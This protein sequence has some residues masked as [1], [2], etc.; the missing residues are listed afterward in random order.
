MISWI[1]DNN[2]FINNFYLVLNDPTNEIIKAFS[3][4]YERAYDTGKEIEYSKYLEPTQKVHESKWFL[5][6]PISA[7]IQSYTCD[8]VIALRG[9]GIQIF[10]FAE[11]SNEVRASQA[12][13]ILGIY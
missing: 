8:R 10:C 2:P 7:F 9:N 4:V 3:Q 1:D 12:T 6:S 13:Y 5:S 11:G